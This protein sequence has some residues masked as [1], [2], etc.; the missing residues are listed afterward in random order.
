[1]TP[2][3]APLDLEDRRALFASLE[4]LQKQITLLIHRVIDSPTDPIPD[5]AWEHLAMARIEIGAV[6]RN[7]I[8]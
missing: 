7:W 6:T 1:M 2:S 4:G 3:P 8:H 5:S